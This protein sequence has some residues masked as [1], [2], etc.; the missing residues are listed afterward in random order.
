MVYFILNNTGSPHSHPPLPAPRTPPYFPT[1][2]PASHIQ[3]E[4]KQCVL[5]LQTWLPDP[6]WRRVCRSKV[7]AVASELVMGRAPWGRSSDFTHPAPGSLWN[8]AS[9][10]ED[11]S[12]SRVENGG[13]RA[14]A[15]A[16]RRGRGRTR[17]CTLSVRPIC[18]TSVHKLPCGGEVAVQREPT[19]IG[20]CRIQRR[21]RFSH[22][23]EEEPCILAVH[24][25]DQISSSGDPSPGRHVQLCKLYWTA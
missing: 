2:S 7:P 15:D 25:W 19:W 13:E 24:L 4:Q 9:I 6:S 20:Y 14:G 10:W 18:M 21:R 17:G 16:E 12:I 3:S 23:S 1:P 5:S 8:M 11:P 22:F